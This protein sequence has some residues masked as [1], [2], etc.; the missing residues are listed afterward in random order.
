M[1]EHTLTKFGRETFPRSR[2]SSIVYA[3][4]V[5]IYAISMEAEGFQALAV[6]IG[7]TSVLI[8]WEWIR[9][10]KSIGRHFTLAFLLASSHDGLKLNNKWYDIISHSFSRS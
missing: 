3:R 7:N 5:K 2:D 10:M 1:G 4:N 8:A 6:D 9:G